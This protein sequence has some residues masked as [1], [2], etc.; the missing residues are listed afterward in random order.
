MLQR[1][2][3]PTQKQNALWPPHLP[4]SANPQLSPLKTKTHLLTPHPQ[5][6]FRGSRHF[7]EGGYEHIATKLFQSL[8]VSTYYLEYD[9]ARAGTFEPLLHLPPHKNVIVGVVTSKFPELE[10]VAKMKERVFAAADVVAEGAGQTREQ[11][12][13]RMGV[14]PQCGFASHEEGNAIKWRDMEN[15]L[16]LVRKIAEEIWPGE[17]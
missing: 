13:R 5:G 2:H 6:N 3:L 12:L 15:K 9:T 14:S 1:L 16:R 4:R 7:S 10:D 11:A 8:N 17:A